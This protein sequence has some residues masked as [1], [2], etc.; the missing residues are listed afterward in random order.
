MYPWRNGWM[1]FQ[2]WAG[3]WQVRGSL[4]LSASY[5]HPDLCNQP[6]YY[7]ELRRFPDTGYYDH[8][9]SG[10]IN[11]CNSQRSLLPVRHHSQLEH[12]RNDTQYVPLEVLVWMISF[13]PWGVLLSVVINVLECVW[14]KKQYQTYVLIIPYIEQK[15]HNLIIIHKK[16]QKA[17][18]MRLKCNFYTM[19]SFDANSSRHL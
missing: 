17:A 4:L 11:T 3:H 19:F 18:K 15:Y 8:Q 5:T 12:R 16:M 7:P 2:G 6:V 10:S 1:L 14:C 13:C 9:A